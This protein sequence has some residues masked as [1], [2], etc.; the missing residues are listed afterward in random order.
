MQEMHFGAGLPTPQPTKAPLVQFSR[1]SIC[2]S[3]KMLLTFG[4]LVGV[5]AL[6]MLV[7]SGINNAGQKKIATKSRAEGEIA[8][9]VSIKDKYPVEMGWLS[10]DLDFIR[11][12]R[13]AMASKM[14]SDQTVDKPSVESWMWQNERDPD[15]YYQKYH[16][17]VHLKFG[18][19]YEDVPRFSSGEFK[20]TGCSPKILNDDSGSIFRCAPYNFSISYTDN[21]YNNNLDLPP[22]PRE[23]FVNVYKRVYN[24]DSEKYGREYKNIWT[25]FK[26]VKNEIKVLVIPNSEDP[27]DNVEFSVYSAING[28]RYNSNPVQ[29]TLSTVPFEEITE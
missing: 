6:G 23:L 1:D 26:L 20:Y 7:S 16:G 5:F 28:D 8:S 27:K 11:V 3:R 18:L 21:P 12:Y 24:S 15:S 14:S 9:P 19:E 2:V 17:L 25:S 13:A 4:V 22:V 29:V 10:N